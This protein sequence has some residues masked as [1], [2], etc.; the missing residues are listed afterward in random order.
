MNVKIKKASRS[1]AGEIL[2]V[3]KIAFESEGR[4]YDNPRIAPLVETL[5]DVIRDFDTHVILKAVVET[6]EIAGSVR[7]FANGSTCWISRLFVSPLYQKL[8]IGSRLMSEIE[9]CFP[10]TARFELAAGNK[11]VRSI[12]LYRKLGYVILGEIRKDNATLLRMGKD[13]VKKRK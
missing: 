8:G 4:L 1:D 13:T 9:K 3:Q 11:S 2:R 5:E 6:G 10:S 12:G 7:G